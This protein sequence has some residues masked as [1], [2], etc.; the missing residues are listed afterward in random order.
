MTTDELRRQMNNKLGLGMWPKT[1]NVDAETYGNVCHTIFTSK[2][3]IPGEDNQQVVYIT[4]GPH[5]G[6]MFKG[7]ELILREK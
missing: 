4:L 1:Y 3:F 6:I 5:N 2:P 7:V